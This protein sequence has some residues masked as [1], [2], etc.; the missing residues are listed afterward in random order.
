LL[1]ARTMNTRLTAVSLF[2]Q[3]SRFSADM[4]AMFTSSQLVQLASYIPGV[5]TPTDPAVLKFISDKG[6]LKGLTNAERVIA[7][8]QATYGTK[9]KERSVKW[10]EYVQMT[11]TDVTATTDK[12]T[13]HDG[14][15]VEMTLSPIPTEM[16]QRLGSNNLAIF[17][18]SI[19]DIRGGA[20]TSSMT[21]AA[22]K[23]I[24][25]Q[26]LN[27]PSV[28]ALSVSIAEMLNTDPVFVAVPQIKKSAITGALRAKFLV[29][30]AN[31]IPLVDYLVLHGQIVYNC[32]TYWIKLVDGKGVAL[33]N[34]GPEPEGFNKD[35]AIEMYRTLSVTER[36]SVL[37]S[38]NNAPPRLFSGRPTLSLTLDEVEDEKDVKSVI[39]TVGS[40]VSSGMVSRLLYSMKGFTGIMTDM[41]KRVATI[42][43]IAL[44]RFLVGQPV[45]VFLYS[46]GDAIILVES[47]QKAFDMVYDVEK[48]KGIE[49]F[50]LIVSHENR[51]KVHIPEKYI[52]TKPRERVSVNG[53]TV[54]V[55]QIY[56]SDQGLPS[57]L[58]SGVAIDWEGEAR[59]Y[60][61][62]SKGQ[63]WAYVG[64]IFGAYMFGEDR[65]IS[66]S[67]KS[68]VPPLS[69]SPITAY[70]W[71]DGSLMR[72]VLSNVPLKFFGAVVSA[73]SNDEVVRRPDE[74]SVDAFVSSRAWYKYVRK[75]C[76]VCLSAWFRPVSRYSSCTNLIRQTKKGGVVTS[77]TQFFEAG[78][79]KQ[80]E[81]ASLLYA[82]NNE[83][84][85][86]TPE[87]MD[88]APSSTAFNM[89]PV[90]NSDVGVD[91]IVLVPPASSGASE[92]FSD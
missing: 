76:G 15:K 56:Y 44:G 31:R 66:T 5:H 2:T 9:T 87:S 91:D 85:L 27:L 16:P 29:E 38:M 40:I 67:M 46:V 65:P 81:L 45:D 83:I 49:P 24:F 1:D 47:L 21:M 62:F 74:I 52:E 20:W 18:G 50:K 25:K 42:C 10:D 60:V 61:P 75:E 30:W 51:P 73:G 92:F 68:V 86:G 57:A 28:S 17:V 6:L 59:K 80:D 54:E 90:V 58:V 84:P 55:L 13:I 43:S 34:A 4:V 26:G 32:F 37:A 70:G 77:T 53:G 33:V 78:Q 19:V 11:G 12:L 69:S 63:Q 36:Q 79:L 35:K 82:L 48:H 39:E 23:K 71:G 88:D 7:N 22:Y 89:V 8:T 41:G 64:P 72:G 14:K 3:T